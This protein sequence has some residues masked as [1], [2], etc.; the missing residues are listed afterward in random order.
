[1]PA[2]KSNFLTYPTTTIPETNM[3][4][5]QKPINHNQTENKKQLKSKNEQ[6]PESKRSV[7]TIYH[8][9]AEE[10]K[11]MANKY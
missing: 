3:F 11:L 8:N 6:I 4:V 2:H 10:K 9:Y 7:I 5:K 1:M